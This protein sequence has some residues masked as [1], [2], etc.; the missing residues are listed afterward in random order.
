M[1][2]LKILIW[3]S[4]LIAVVTILFER[5]WKGDRKEPF[6]K[7]LLDNLFVLVS[8]TISLLILLESAVEKGWF[9]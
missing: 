3:L 5:W 7:T 6:Y 8:L 2:G 1:I 4:P 9:R